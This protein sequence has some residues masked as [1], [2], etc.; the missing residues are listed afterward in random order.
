MRLIESILSWSFLALI[1]VFIVLRLMKARADRQ[2]LGSLEKM[3]RENRDRESALQRMIRDLSATEERRRTLPAGQRTPA[4]RCEYDEMLSVISPWLR[5]HHSSLLESATARHLVPTYV[6]SLA[7]SERISTRHL[8]LV[9]DGGERRRFFLYPD[10]VMCAAGDKLLIRACPDASSAAVASRGG[11]H[12]V[13]ARDELE[14]R[15]RTSADEKARSAAEYSTTVVDERNL[16]WAWKVG[17]GAFV[18]G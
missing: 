14:W 4:L 3:I 18:P 17:R 13:S 12:V 5:Q 6:G 11:Y 9:L 15:T 2:R 16:S 1:P 8:V 7:D 10:R